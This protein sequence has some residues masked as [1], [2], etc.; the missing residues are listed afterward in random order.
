[1]TAKPVGRGPATKAEVGIKNQ[2][3]LVERLRA[4]QRQDPR[5]KRC[6]DCGEIGP[7][8]VCMDYGTFICTVCSGLHREIAHRVKGVSL[9]EWSPE[10]VNFIL[11]HGN[12]AADEVYL[13]ELN[14]QRDR[15][16]SGNAEVE[17]LRVWIRQKYVDKKWVAGG[18]AAAAR[19]TAATT[20]PQPS[21]PQH[22]FQQ[23]KSPLPPRRASVKPAKP[24]KKKETTTTSVDLLDLNF[25]DPFVTT[26]ASGPSSQQPLFFSDETAPR[27]PP[28]PQS[29]ETAKQPSLFPPNDLSLLDLTSPP[30][31]AAPLSLEQPNMLLFDGSKA[32]GVAKL[33]AVAQR[34]DIIDAFA[35][36]VAREVVAPQRYE[37]DPFTSIPLEIPSVPRPPGAASSPPQPVEIPPAPPLSPSMTLG[38]LGP[39]SRKSSVASRDVQSSL[40]ILTKQLSALQEAVAAESPRFLAAEP[41]APPLAAPPARRIPSVDFGVPAPT[42]TSHALGM[43]LSEQEPPPPLAFGGERR[44]SL[45]TGAEAPPPPVV[46]PYDSTL[47][48]AAVAPGAAPWADFDSI[49]PFAEQSSFN[50]QQHQGQKR[51]KNP[52]STDFAQMQGP[53]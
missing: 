16:P 53:L 15:P 27:P 26:A 40:D 47:G 29:L 44:P 8:Y 38:E 18:P 30:T 22:R 45:P 52:F 11:E 6:A 28:P 36:R 37:G 20:T 31:A 43:G 34:P 51:G 7:T 41:L 49:P 17:R 48:A 19:K 50:E 23:E 5:N 33:A 10:E 39:P 2:E 1:M 35:S 12:T 24:R 46:A 25:E 14:P 13:K 32:E 9:S 3:K 21:S 4:F 42:T